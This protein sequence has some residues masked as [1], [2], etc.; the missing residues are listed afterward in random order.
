MKTLI[1]LIIA[2]FIFLSC[3]SGQDS[4][5]LNELNSG[6]E[7]IIKTSGSKSL[8]NYFIYN[9][10]YRFNLPSGWQQFSENFWYRVEADLFPDDFSQE[11][12]QQFVQ[13]GFMIEKIENQVDLSL[14][15]VV[16]LYGLDG[17]KTVRQVLFLKNQSARKFQRAGVSEVETV[18]ILKKGNVYLLNFWGVGFSK[19]EYLGFSEEEQLKII[20][21]NEEILSSF[22]LF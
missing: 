11:A 19:K 16:D 17:Q 21:E 18:V 9:E 8:E 22:E 12:F 14:D 4:L 13:N 20:Q 6:S 5:Q 7:I 15:Q 2:L 3:D 1:I 10:D